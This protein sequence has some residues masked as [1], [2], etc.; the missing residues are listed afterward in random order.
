MVRSLDPYYPVL[1]RSNHTFPRLSTLLRLSQDYS[2]NIDHKSIR[3]RSTKV[4]KRQSCLRS[5][6][7]LLYFEDEGNSNPDTITILRL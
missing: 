7:A 3:L 2:S 5:K 1:M 6:T 4:C